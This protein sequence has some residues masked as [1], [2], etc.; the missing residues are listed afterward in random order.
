V[1]SDGNETSGLRLPE[2]AVPLATYM[3]WGFR[4]AAIGAPD[5]LLAMVGS[6]LPFARTRAER[7]KSGDPRPSI[8]ERYAS[9]ADYV[10]RVEEVTKRLVRERYILQEDEGRIVN[11]ATNHWDVLMNTSKST[12]Q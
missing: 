3:G 2:Q 8:E 6:Y 9:R 10:Q 7:D 4:S 12:K 5:E 1:D 11:R